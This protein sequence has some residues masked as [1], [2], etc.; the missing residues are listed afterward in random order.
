M[1]AALVV[2]AVAAALAGM[3]GLTRRHVE[4]WRDGASFLRRE[5]VAQ[6]A[7][8]TTRNANNHNQSLAL[9]QPPFADVPDA[10]ANAA[11]LFSAANDYALEL[12]RV[13]RGP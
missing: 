8:T 3:C 6:A 5:Y 13:G 9:S 2:A 1:R 12:H 10:E 11:G 4:A 7:A